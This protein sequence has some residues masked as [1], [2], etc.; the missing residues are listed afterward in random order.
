MVGAQSLF[1]NEVHHLMRLRHPN[2]VR[3][4][5]YCYETKKVILEYRG[6]NVFAER[7]EMLLCLEYLPKGSLDGYISVCVA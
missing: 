1:E 4:M 6:K 7:S 5:G 3:L 2:I